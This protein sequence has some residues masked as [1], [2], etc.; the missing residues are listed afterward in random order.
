MGDVLPSWKEGKTRKSILDFVARVTGEGGAD[1]VPPEAR[2]AVFDNDGTLWCEQPFPI[3]TGFLFAKLAEQVKADPSLAAKQPWK[4]VVEN[5]HAWLGNVITKHYQGD[6]SDLKLMGAGLLSAYA[7]DDVE[8]FATKAEA[9]LRQSQ[10]PV[11]K[12]DS[13]K[14]AY[15]P[16]RELLQYLEDH[17]FTNFI[18]SGGGRDFMRP[19]TRELYGIPPDRVIGTTV[20]LEY[21]EVEGRGGVYHTD[22]LELFDDGPAKVVQ[23]WSRIGA[24]PLFVAGNSNGDLPMMRFATDG[25]GPS[26]ALLVRHDDGKRD[27]AYDAGAE[28]AQAMAAERGWVVAS[29]RDDW[30]TVFVD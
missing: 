8:G 18:V 9:F 26:L 30:S 3:Q 15:A 21:R 22:R 17:G 16:M 24:R 28:Q 25:P 29:V 20:A 14:T 5:D 10:N 11:L 13:L 1:Y 2:I 7:G 27:I 6:D 12:R 23:I 19:V 4:A